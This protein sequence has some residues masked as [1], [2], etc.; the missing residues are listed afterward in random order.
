M[1]VTEDSHKIVELID[2]RKELSDLAIKC[3]ENESNQND[4]VGHL[5]R[6]EEARIPELGGD[7]RLKEP[8][9]EYILASIA[10][11]KGQYRPLEVGFPEAETRLLEAVK[12]AFEDLGAI[13]AAIN[14]V[15]DMLQTGWI[16]STHVYARLLA[17]LPDTLISAAGADGVSVSVCDPG[18]TGVIVR[19]VVNP[20][21][22]PDDDE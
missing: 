13:M 3:L 6:L 9:G 2:P 10:S 22:L 15:V 12:T 21:R 17:L 5:E 1:S 20:K 16:T 11:N 8:I 4:F 18:G 7:A 19:P 14:G